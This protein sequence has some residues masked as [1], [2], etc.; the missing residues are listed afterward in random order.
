MI[1][2]EWRA[3]PLRLAVA[4]YLARYKGETRRHTESD[5]RAYLTWC[6]ERGLNPLAA[7]RPHVEL[8]VRWMQETRRYAASTVSRG[9]S[10]GPQQRSSRWSAKAGGGW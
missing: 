5:L 2:D 10:A 1:D 9:G 8:Y 7:K 3:D 6:Q 4:G